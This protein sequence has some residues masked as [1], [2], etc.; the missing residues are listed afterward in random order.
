[1]NA[2]GLDI[3]STTLKIVEVRKEGGKHRIIAAG[4]TPTP[5]PGIS[6]EAEK[7]VVAVSSAIKKLHQD[8]RIGAKEAVIALPEGQVFSR[9]IEVPPMGDNELA[10]AIPWQAEQFIPVP[11]EQVNLDWQVVAR[12]GGGKGEEKMKILLVAA[13]LNLI[14]KYV[15]YVEMAGF[16][17]AAVET[18]IVASAR[19]LIP[20]KSPPVMLVDFGAKTT[21]L[22]VVQDGYVVMTRSIPTAGEAFTRAI[23]TT[24]SLTPAQAEEYKITYG[25]GENQLEGKVRKALT[26]IFEVVVAEIK[27]ALSFWKQNEKEPIS[28]IILTGGSANLPQAAPFFTKSLGIEVQIGDPFANLVPDEKILGSLRPNAPLFVVAVGLAEKEI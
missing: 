11:L 2:F 3:G 14:Q 15:R 23:A 22:A 26:P 18:E 25:L 4:L 17:T 21:D 28:L 12:G 10:Q 7:D 20:P 27:K 6:S 5:R 24:L 1:M 16:K 8:A 19:A 13:P 9:V